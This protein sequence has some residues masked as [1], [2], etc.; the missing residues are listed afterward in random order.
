MKKFQLA[1]V[2]A[3]SAILLA[4][5]GGAPAP[6][7]TPALSTQAPTVAVQ[8]TEAPQPTPAPTETSQPTEAPPAT[9]APVA[10]EAP[11]ATE[12]LAE[13]TLL[14]GAFER[15]MYNGGGEAHIVRKADGMLELRLKG[16][17]VDNGPALYV[18][19]S[20]QAET[21]KTSGQGDIPGSV[22]LA[23]LQALS[24]DQTYDLPAGTDV[25]NLKA[26]VIWCK[27]FSVGFVAASLAA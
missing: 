17:T 2:G 13:T 19:L 21:P 7:P 25:S 26:I 27:E 24:G 15:V 4:A 12:A 3:A 6:T 10:T 8:P 14:K 5:C 18:Y 16:F 1:L 23:P 11:A 22:A 9:E 20:P